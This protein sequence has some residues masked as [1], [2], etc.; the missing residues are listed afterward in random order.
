MILLDT[1][2]LLWWSTEP[3]LLSQAATTAIENGDRIGVAGITWFELAWLAKHDRIIVTMPVRNWLDGLASGVE[4]IDLTPAIADLATSLPSY[5]PGDPADRI[6]YATALGAGLPL[7][8]KDSR[9][10]DNVV[11]I[12]FVV[13]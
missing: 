4:T 10:R 5:F 12:P 7:V 9:M 6:I 1:H 3:D 13:W 8:S 2:V 11:P